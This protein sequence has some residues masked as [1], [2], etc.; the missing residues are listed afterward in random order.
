MTQ[1]LTIPVIAIDGYSGTGKGTTRSIVAKKLGFHELDSGVLYR[2]AGVVVYEHGVSTEQPADI[3][4]L[5]K[6]FDVKTEGL[7]VFIGGED[8]TALIRSD[9]VGSKFSSAIAKHQCIRDF[10]LEYEL[11]MRKLP[12]LV[13]DGRD[14][15]NI[16]ET[17]YRFFIKTDPRVKAE[18]RVKQFK[19]EQGRTVSFEKV[20]ED[21][22][23]RD[24]ADETRTVSP[25]KPHPKAM[26][27]DNTNMARMEVVEQILSFYQKNPLF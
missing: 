8:K 17:P 21:I 5:I 15:G 23:A 16:F 4:P 2:A 19:E 27:I 11:S 12:G 22:I 10:L 9:D 20:L 25:L 13:A 6:N 26:I 14:M 1:D 7:K 24:T 18:R 3:L